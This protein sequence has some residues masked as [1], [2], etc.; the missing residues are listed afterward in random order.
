MTTTIAPK[1]G[2]PARPLTPMQAMQVSDAE[3][4]EFIW[5]SAADGRKTVAQ[6][7]AL[8]EE[9]KGMLDDLETVPKLPRKNGVLPASP[10]ALARRGTDRE[11]QMQLSKCS[12]SVPTK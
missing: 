10:D 2:Q 5:Q 3:F 4:L 7:R 8:I 11:E 1:Q 12:S 6:S 9:T